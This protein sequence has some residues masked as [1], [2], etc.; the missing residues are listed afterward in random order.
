MDDAISNGVPTWFLIFYEAY[1]SQMSSILDK[2]PSTPSYPALS[3]SSSTSSINTDIEMKG[4]LSPH[5]VDPALLRKMSLNITLLEAGI[6]F[7]S[8]F[9]GMTLSVTTDGFLLF[10]VAI[11][12]HQ[13]FEGLGLGSRIAAVPYPSS[14]LRPW[15]LCLAFGVTTPIGQVIGLLLRNSYDPSSGMALIMVGTF[16][17]VSAGLLVYAALVDL[18]VEDFLSE[19]ASMEMSG[20]KKAGAVCF[21]GMGAVGMGVVG[22]FA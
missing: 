8:I 15:L 1:T 12:F 10:L 5:P 16:N 14:S 9:I 3:P 7:H 11:L 22:A 20:A 6:L 4:D 17:A 13:T 19:R 21:V 18:L 2:L